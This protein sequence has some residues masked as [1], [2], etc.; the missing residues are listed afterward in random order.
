[1]QLLREKKIRD[2]AMKNLPI[3]LWL[4]LWGSICSCLA[5]QF[6]WSSD[7][8]EYA[9]RSCNPQTI[10]NSKYSEKNTK[11]LNVYRLS[12]LNSL[13]YIIARYIKM[14]QKIIH[15]FIKYIANVNISSFFYLRKYVIFLTLSSMGFNCGYPYEKKNI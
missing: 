12:R 7:H 14:R 4:F 5:W 9:N 15:F 1:M 13:Q 6:P 11:T 3:V 10:N 2:S 8:T